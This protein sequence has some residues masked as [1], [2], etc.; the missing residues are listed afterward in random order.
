M[1]SAVY[2][3]TLW[4]RVAHW[5]NVVAMTILLMSGLQIFNA[6]PALDWGERSGIDAAGNPGTWQDGTLKLRAF[7]WWTTLP[8]RQWLAMGRRWHFFFAWIFVINGVAFG[9]YALISRHLARDLLPTRGELAHLPNA[10]ADHAHLR[11]PEGEAA[12]RYNV[13][14]KLAYLVAVFVLGPLIVLAGLAM[15]PALDAGFPGLLALFGGRQSARTIHFLCAFAFLGF[16]AI[17]LTMVVLSGV[18]N[19]L[20]SM[21]T[22]R[23][24][25]DGGGGDG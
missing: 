12:K 19:N 24:V 8:G 5:I 6:H 21:I 10:V 25:I 23:Y 3:H 11:F 2:R 16:V 18:W 4:V 1:S 14:Q 15:S 17:H 7:P 9:A 13:L 20:R 22:G